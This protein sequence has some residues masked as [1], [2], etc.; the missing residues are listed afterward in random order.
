M[1]SNA[2]PM[3]NGTIRRC[4]LVGVGG[5][6]LE[7]VYHCGLGFE[8]SSAQDRPGMEFQFPTVALGSKYRIISSSSTKFACTMPYF[9]P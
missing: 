8:A 5:A 7:E 6:L 9:P 1:Y 4:S 2:W 3:G